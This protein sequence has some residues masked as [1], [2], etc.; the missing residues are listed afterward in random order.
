MLLGIEQLI[1]DPKLQSKL[2]N[3]RCALVG[4]PASVTQQLQHSLDVLINQTDLTMT[5]AFGPQHGMRGDVQDNMIETADYLDPIHQIPVFS[6]YGE[7]RRPTETMLD[8]VDV[9]LFD[10]QD[11]GCRIYTYI[12]TLLYLLEACA[13]T[14]KSIWVLD[15]PNP[16]GR[17]IE[18]NI[19]ESGWESF[20]G[21]SQIITRHGLTVGEL[22]K[23][24]I[25]HHN[26]D[27]DCEIITMKNYDPC[28]KPGYG[29][30]LGQLNWV[31]P[32]PNASSLN[33]AR[34]FPGT[35]LLE[36]TQLSE[37]RGTTIAME[38]VGAPDIDANAIMKTMEKIKPDCFQG[39]LV[40][41][42][43]FEPTFHKHQ[44]SLCQGFQIHTEYDD[45]QPQ[46]FKPF[47]LIVL[48]L[49][50][51]RLQQPDY[52]IWR[53]HDYEYE[54]GRLPIDV[55]NGG[56]FIREWIDDNNAELDDLEKRLQ[57]DEKRWRESMQDC[58]LYPI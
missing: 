5:A 46:Q 37:G 28:Q 56:P 39:C 29:W 23:W 26:L 36:G 41:P 2:H 44:G 14:G 40:R 34:C 11:I 1:N 57:T 19:L 18:G 51:L 7:V 15:R 47:R 24:F 20:V 3:K 45:Y 13:A 27:V 22:A 43:Y 50:A 9:F 8:C 35:V 49:K 58:L 53:N 48:F 31:N 4:H 16:I 17:A 25:K 54:F 33:M 55:I 32:S 12:C 52:E 10:L 21:P 30:P 38:V 42:C 6:L